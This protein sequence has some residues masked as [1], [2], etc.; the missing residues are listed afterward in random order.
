M[1]WLHKTKHEDG[2]NS[3]EKKIENLDSLQ[4]KINVQ[5]EHL[6]SISK[7]LEVV[8]GEYGEVISSL[9]SAKKELAEKRKEI[10]LLK[11]LSQD[12]QKKS[13]KGDSLEFKKQLE[14][15]DVLNDFMIKQEEVEKQLQKTNSKLKDARLELENIEGKKHKIF[16]GLIKKNNEKIPTSKKLSNQ[17]NDSKSVVQAASAVIA[18]MHTKLTKAEKE[19]E[20]MVKLLEEEREE[21]QKTKKEL[22]NLKSKD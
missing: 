17:K 4:N 3:T 13:K 7:K 6:D 9:M 1:G 19:L 15:E 16:E 12:E 21:H 14:M 5:Q 18:T 2:S 20:T 8:K 22:D 11:S 10:S